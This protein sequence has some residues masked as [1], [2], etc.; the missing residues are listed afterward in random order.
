MTTQIAVAQSD[1]RRLLRYRW[2]VLSVP[3]VCNMVVLFL[4]VVPATIGDQL[5]SAWHLDAVSLGLLGSLMFYPYALLQIPSG[6]LNDKWGPRRTV[7]AAMLIMAV[8]QILFSQAT[9]LG[10]G[11]MGRAITGLGSAGIFISVLKVLVT[12]FRVREFATLLGLNATLAFAGSMLGTAP[13]AFLVIRLGWEAPLL[14]VGLFTFL[15]AAL[16]WILIRDDPAEIGLPPIRTV[17]P[18]AEST[19]TDNVSSVDYRSLIKEAA[20]IWLRTP[21]IWIV[22]LT[23]LLGLGSLQAFQ[24]L[25]AGP[26][27]IHVHGKTA[28]TAGASLLLLSVGAGLGAAVSGYLSDQVKSR[29]PFLIGGTVG[30]TA[31]WAGIVATTNGASTLTI[32]LLF[33]LFSFS[34]GF[35][36]IGQP[37]VKEVVRPAIFGTVFGIVNMF[38]FVGNA[39]LQLLMGALLN[40]SDATVIDGSRVYSAAGYWLAFMPLLIGAFLCIVLALLVPESLKRTPVETVSASD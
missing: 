7:T 21:T 22:S 28:V 19:A 27:L 35:I 32:N 5:A 11:L 34:A 17:D 25:W 15:L 13:L 1:I 20:Q 6:I 37:M 16:S 40:T 23:L 33:V 26:Y 30:L 12:W 3:V 18:D 10:M 8:G 9:E 29:R 2:V 36:L 24:S 31:A 39:I 14:M 38:P 4:F